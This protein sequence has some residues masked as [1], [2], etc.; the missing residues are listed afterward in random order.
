[1][2]LRAKAEYPQVNFQRSVM[3]G[4]SASDLEMGRALGMVTVLIG[5]PW[6]DKSHL[7]DFHYPSLRQ[8]ADEWIA[9]RPTGKAE[10]IVFTPDYWNNRYLEKASP[11][12]LGKPSAPLMDF[13]SRWTDKSARILLPG[14]GGGHEA[15][16][17]YQMGYTNI[18]LLD[19]SPEVCALF[20][21]NYPFFP[22]TQVH[23]EDF[24]QHQ[25]QYDL[26]LEQT[27]FCALPITLRDR[28]VQHMASILKPGGTLAG[29]MFNFPIVEAGPPW[30]GDADEYRRRFE[31]YFD[32]LEMKECK[33]SEPSRLGRELFVQ[34]RR[35]EH[36]AS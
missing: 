15:A 24:F 28:Y 6:P 36:T 13:M 19:W 12:D 29:V 11:W 34:F 5:A 20:L 1:M 10:D 30:G 26:V 9:G 18:H 16:A 21:R 2:P 17:L 7:F 32:I 22:P 23:C 27:F 25:H 8:W 3:V 33:T 31:S 14:G 4:D 35:K